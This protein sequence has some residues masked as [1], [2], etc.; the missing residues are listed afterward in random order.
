M[1]DLLSK[2]LL[3][4]ALLLGSLTVP[5]VHAAENPPLERLETIDV[6][7]FTAEIL[8]YCPTQHLLLATNPHW[9]SIDLFDVESLDPPRLTPLD[10]DDEEPGIQG[11]EFVG[12]PT[13]VA[14]HPTLPI[15]FVVVTHPVP[16]QP[17]T[18]QAFDLRRDGDRLGGWIL[19]QKIGIHPDSLAI[20]PDGRWLI[21]A[22]EAQGDPTSP[23]SIWSLDLKGL[24]PDR[25]ARDGNL[26]A[27]PLPGL[28]RLM[29]HPLGDLEPEYVAFDPQSRLA[30]VTFQEND[31]F[32]TV[33]LVSQPTPRLAAVTRLSYESEPDGI[34]L[35]DQVPGPDGHPGLLVAVAEEGKF[36]RFGQITGNCVSFHWLDPNAPDQPA[37][38]L[39]RVDVRPL[40]SGNKP[41]KRRDPEAVRL[42]RHGGRLLALVGVERG[43]CVMSFDLTDP[44]APRYLGQTP[45][46]ERPEGLLLVRDDHQTYLLTGDEGSQG[47]GTISVLRLRE[48]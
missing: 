26:P 9:K 21:V 22:C 32:V 12:E 42:L 25:R 16:N 35:I 1:A 39:S 33:D 5:V 13:S 11:F 40:L 23:G 29:D 15:A 4:I 47:P 46:G 20:S 18:V 7:G 28:A 45:V 17:G 14:V 41:A 38:L 44:A 24:S 2:F 3:G 31:S 30:V 8:Q 6:P 19:N 34:D 43:D 48:P 37:V 36:N 27:T 10:L